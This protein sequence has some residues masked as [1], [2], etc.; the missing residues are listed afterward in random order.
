[1]LRRTGERTASSRAPSAGEVS[2]LAADAY[3][4]GYPLVLMDVTR[5]VATSTMQ[6]ALGR[7]PT[8]TFAHMRSLPDASYTDVV[9]PNAD[10]LYSVAWLDLREQP[11]V[12]GLPEMGGRYYLMQMLDGW[13]NVFADPGTRTLGGESREFA[14]VGPDWREPLPPT[15]AVI[16]AP[17]NM[18]WIIGRTQTDGH[19][20]YIAVHAAQDKYLLTPL[21]EWGTG[22][23]PPILAT[24]TAGIDLHTPPAEQVAGMDA[25]TFFG[26]LNVLMQTNPPAAIDARALRRFERLGIRP[27]PPAADNLHS[28]LGPGMSAGR[29]RLL[30]IA[31]GH[32]VG[33]VVNGWEFAP[34]EIGRYGTNYLLRAAVAMVGLGA[35]LREDAIYPRAIVDELGQ[36]LSGAQRYTITFPYGGLPP[37]S[38]FWS[39]TL[40]NAQR[41]FVE[42]PIHRYAIGDRDDLTMNSDGSLT[43]YVQHESPGQA[44]EGNWLPAPADAF[45][46]IMRLYWPSAS[47]LEGRWTPPPVRRSVR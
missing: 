2:R 29:T 47:I 6:P 39:I 21:S 43:I 17:T 14:I 1:V 44:R 11:M 46:L 3:I 22:Y 8:N 30:E 41:T 23:Q 37:V 42:N 38:A 10:A 35:N 33:H 4:F 25:A 27:G 9:S 16:R 20:D 19:R 31:H 7:A 28:S 13:T 40:Y 15:L 18:V 5:H 12:L 24:D 32:I 45:N 36:P 34:R 26:C